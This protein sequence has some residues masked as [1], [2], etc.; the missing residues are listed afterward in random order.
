MFI[1]VWVAGYFIHSGK[2][3]NSKNIIY[4]VLSVATTNKWF[5]SENWENVDVINKL[6]VVRNGLGDE[7]RV[8]N[9]SRTF[10]SNVCCGILRWLMVKNSQRHVFASRKMR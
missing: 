8:L 3:D 5:M 2:F 10:N 6:E 4:E 7:S 1:G 9:L